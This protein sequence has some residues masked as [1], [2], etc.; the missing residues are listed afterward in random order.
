MP[1]SGLGHNGDAR[2]VHDLLNHARVGRPRDP[3]VLLYVGRDALER[4]HGH[5]SRPLRDARLRSGVGTSI[6]QTDSSLGGICSQSNS[7]YHFF[8]RSFSSSFSHCR[9]ILTTA[10]NISLIPLILILYSIL[11]RTDS[12]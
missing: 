10:Y 1:D 9:N 11:S 2:G 4:H 12:L 6:Q 5:R 3:A 8:S 7:F